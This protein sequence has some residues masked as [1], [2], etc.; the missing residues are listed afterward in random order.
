MLIGQK[1]IPIRRRQFKRFWNWFVKSKCP[2][3]G[4]DLI[5][6][7]QHEHFI[8]STSFP[9]VSEDGEK[10]II[11]NFIKNVVFKQVLLA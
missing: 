10:I 3:D 9:W 2:E 5:V 11:L 1:K 6:N 7:F 4:L 8:V